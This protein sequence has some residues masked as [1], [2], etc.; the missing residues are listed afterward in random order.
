[1][2]E[3]HIASA[4]P[5]SQRKATIALDGELAARLEQFRRSGSIDL[6]TPAL[7]RV[8]RGLLEIGLNAAVAR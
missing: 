5:G 3:P 6:P 1:M 4:T 8:V 7:A 2:A